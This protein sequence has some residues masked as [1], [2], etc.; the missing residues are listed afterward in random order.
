MRAGGWRGGH[1]RRYGCFFGRCA[2][3]YNHEVCDRDSDLVALMS[4]GVAQQLRVAPCRTFASAACRAGSGCAR[5]CSQGLGPCYARRVLPALSATIGRSCCS[6]MSS[7][8]SS[9]AALPRCRSSSR[10]AAVEPSPSGVAVVQFE[11][12]NLR[13]SARCCFAAV[14]KRECRPGYPGRGVLS[15]ACA[16]LAMFVIGS[17]PSAEGRSGRRPVIGSACSSDWR[18]WDRPGGRPPRVVEARPSA[19]QAGNAPSIRP[20]VGGATGVI[21]SANVFTVSGAGRGY[22]EKWPASSR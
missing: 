21:G 3:T 7:L 6:H 4:S 1:G 12:G 5:V 11:A 13:I 14:A 10:F 2:G 16:Y 18:A 17:E 8:T 19:L 22:E 20:L 15:N 9:S